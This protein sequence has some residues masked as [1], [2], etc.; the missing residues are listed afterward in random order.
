MAG[1]ALINYK[2]INSDDE[3]VLYSQMFYDFPIL[4][5]TYTGTQLCTFF[6]CSKCKK[7]I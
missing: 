6:F 1:C 3:T 2:N 5:I 4:C 7:F